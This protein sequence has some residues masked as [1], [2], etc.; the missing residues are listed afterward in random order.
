M[1]NGFGLF[2]LTVKEVVAVPVRSGWVPQYDW[3]VAWIVKLPAALNGI[4][5]QTKEYWVLVAIVD[6]AVTVHWIGVGLPV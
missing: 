4:D 3:A 6:E 5:G 2:W 1:L